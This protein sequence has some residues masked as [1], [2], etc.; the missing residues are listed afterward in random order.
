MVFTFSSENDL[1]HV[2]A[3]CEDFVPCEGHWWCRAVEKALRAGHTK[4]LMLES[5]TNPRMQICDIATLTKMAHQ[6][7][8]S[9]FASC[10]AFITTA[11]QKTEGQ[12]DVPL[13]L[14]M[15]ALQS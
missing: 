15:N 8:S 4:L 6:V 11:G 13:H 9:P 3:V 10:C 5:P 1:G 14:S 2:D 12:E 7:G